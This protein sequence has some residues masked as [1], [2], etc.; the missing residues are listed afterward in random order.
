MNNIA[1]GK[2]ME[3]LRNSTD[4]KLVKNEKDYLKW[5]SQLYV[6][7]K[8]LSMI[9]LQYKKVKLHLTLN[10]PAQIGMC[11]LGLRIVLIY[12]L[13]YHFVKNNNCCGNNSRL[14]FTDTDR[15]MYEI[16]TE[17]AY[18]DFNKD[19]KNI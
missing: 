6:R 19:K 8:Y 13:C 11:I 17:G 15:L 10:K 14:L 7:K 2:A 18:E 12:E 9:Q 1:Y 4:I 3:N 16:K 5:T